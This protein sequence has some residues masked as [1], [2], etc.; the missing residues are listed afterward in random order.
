MLSVP[1]EGRDR[2]SA[3]L[4]ALLDVRELAPG[5]ELSLDLGQPHPELWT[6]R[7]ERCTPEL[8]NVA[9]VGALVAQ[10]VMGAI[11][12]ENKAR[13]AGRVRINLWTR[14]DWT[15]R[16]GSMEL[17]EAGGKWRWLAP[18]LQALAPAMRYRPA[19]LNGVPQTTWMSQ[20]FELEF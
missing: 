2:F 15:G 17:R 3:A 6:D 16:V 9:E 12:Q 5:D 20:P 19:T 10:V 4:D 14:V 18:Y 11:A 8:G 7:T 1:P 13:P